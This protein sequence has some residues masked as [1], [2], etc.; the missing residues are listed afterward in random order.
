MILMSVANVPSLYIGD[1]WLTAGHISKQRRMPQS[2][3]W[4]HFF[5]PDPTQST[6]FYTQPNLH[7]TKMQWC[8]KLQIFT[9]QNYCF[10]TQSYMLLC[11]RHLFFA[12]LPFQTHDPSQPTKNKNSRPTTNPTQ[13]MGQPNPWTTLGCPLNSP[14]YFWGNLQ[15]LHRRRQICASL[16]KS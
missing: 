7:T 16:S 6:W 1:C 8:D 11:T 12:N 5:D 10:W 13:P 14:L 4:V 3:P 15:F 2:C 9:K